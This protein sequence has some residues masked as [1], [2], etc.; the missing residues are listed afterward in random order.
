MQ[1]NVAENCM[2]DLAET[3]TKTQQ[4]QQEKSIRPK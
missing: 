3:A 1:A 4:V 2:E